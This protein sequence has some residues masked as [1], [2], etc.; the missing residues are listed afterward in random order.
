M[1][2]ENILTSPDE[3]FLMEGN[4]MLERALTRAATIEDISRGF[5]ARLVHLLQVLIPR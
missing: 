5:Q 2:V 3:A 4:T 1:E